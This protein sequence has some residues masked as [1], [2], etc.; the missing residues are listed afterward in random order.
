MIVRLTALILLC[1]PSLTQTAEIPQLITLTNVGLGDSVTFVCEVPEELKSWWYKQSLGHMPQS[2]ASHVLGKTTLSGGFDPSR[3]TVKKEATKF[4]LIIRNVSKEDEA[5]YFCE[6]RTTYSQTFPNGTFLAVKDHDQQKSV[7]VKQ[8]P[9]KASVLL[10]DSVTL[11]C[12]LLSKNKE[13]AVQ[14]SDE[15]R[16][17]W[18]RAGLKGFDPTIIYTLMDSTDEDLERRCVYSLPKIIQNSSDAGTYYCAVVTCGQILLGEGT[19]VE[20]RIFSR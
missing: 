6:T 19:K 18:F 17:Y 8:I 4:F 1:T 3:F 14:C 16:V 11:Q 9:K 2:V 13:N 12:S 15:D 20:T 10:G 5:A 7:Y